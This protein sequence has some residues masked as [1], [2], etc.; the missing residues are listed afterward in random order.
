MDLSS[1]A[2]YVR[3][4]KCVPGPF[5]PFCFVQCCAPVNLRPFLQVVHMLDK[6]RL[7]HED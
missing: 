6:T 4:G 2:F 1:I 7:T 5:D 3:W